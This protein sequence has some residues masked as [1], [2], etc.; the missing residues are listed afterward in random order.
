MSPSF[1]PEVGVHPI[2]T[3]SQ[4]VAS[5]FLAVN[6]FIKFLIRLQKDQYPHFRQFYAYSVI[7]NIICQ[8]LS[9]FESQS[10]FCRRLWDVR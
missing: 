7:R 8:N 6:M 10:L 3:E 5:V 1:G 4:R 2:S 9:E